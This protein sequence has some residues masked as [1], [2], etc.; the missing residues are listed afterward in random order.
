MRCLTRDVPPRRVW[1]LE[2]AGVHPLLAQLFAARGVNSPEELDTQFQR[3]L[4]PTTLQGAAEA[5][6]LLELQQS[7]QA[8]A[9]IMTVAKDLF[10][11]LLR[12]CGLRTGLYTSTH[13]LDPRERI[14]FDG[15]PGLVGAGSGREDVEDHLRAVEHLDA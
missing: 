5:A 4:A 2:Q 15:E 14:V 3:L 13:L 6:R 10:E 8:T 9:Q 1:A 11:S 7:Y 12:A